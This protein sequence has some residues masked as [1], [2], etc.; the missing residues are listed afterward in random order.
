MA[1]SAPYFTTD[2]EEGETQFRSDVTTANANAEIFE[3]PITS[4]TSSYPIS[5]TGSAGTTVYVKIT[6]NGST[7][8][9][10]NS[11]THSGGHDGN[12][13]LYFDQYSVDTSGDAWSQVVTEGVKFE[14]FSDSG[15]NTPTTLNS[16]ATF[17]WH[18]GTC[19]TN[20]NITPTGTAAGTAVYAVY[21]T[22]GGTTS[23]NRIGN[24]TS[25]I[26]ADVH[27]VALIDDSNSFNHITMVPNGH[28]ELFAMGG[29]LLFSQVPQGSIPEGSGYT[30]SVPPEATFNPANDSSGVSKSSSITISLTEPIRNTDDTT[31]TNDNVDSVITLKDTNSSGS[32]ISFDATINDTK[33]TITITPTSNFTAGQTVYA[34]ISNA[35]EDNDDNALAATTSTFTVASAGTPSASI[36]PANG[37][38]GISLSRNIVITFDEAVRIISGNATLTNDN[39]DALIT[40]K[41]TNAQGADIAFD[42][43]VSSDK[44]TITINPTSNFSKNQIVYAALGDTLEDVDDNA[45]SGI[46]T[47]FTTTSVSL[48]NPLNKSDVKAVIES[49]INLS[50][51]FA[52]SSLNLI[53]RRISWLERNIHNP[54]KSRQQVKFLFGN[55]YLDRLINENYNFDQ[56]KKESNVDNN[57]DNLLESENLENFG[58]LITYTKTDYEL[59]TDSYEK[60]LVS[61]NLDNAVYLSGSEAENKVF[62]DLLKIGTEKALALK[63]INKISTT[64]SYESF[65]DG[66][67]IWSSG[68]IKVGSINLRTD[69]S[70]QKFENNI[71]S[72]GMDKAINENDY[73]GGAIVLGDSDI[74]IGTTSTNMNSNNLGFLSYR[75]FTLSENSNFR[76]IAGL[77]KL[78]I[79][80]V[81]VDGTDNLTG[82]RK[83]NQIYSLLRYNK[84][85]EETEND[86]RYSSFNKL[87]FIHTELDHYNE[88]GGSTGLIFEKEN[89]NKALLSTGL[90]MKHKYGFKNSFI[91][92]PFIQAEYG[93]DISRGSKSHIRY[94]DDT[95]MYSSKNNNLYSTIFTGLIGSDI[96]INDNSSAQITYEFEN[97]TNYSQHHTL[98]F[99]INY[100]F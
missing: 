87:K 44:T 70:Q 39:V 81:R 2:T 38:T 52:N 65:Y 53:D 37:S 59:N 90:E 17:T 33:T 48:E 86:W 35:V 34:A 26:S 36:S 51:N 85:L 13:T 69:T 99:T 97:A 50:S 71:L 78:D 91:I 3:L 4:S 49:Y 7:S 1:V 23:T 61:N 5:V 74:D 22:T 77:G 92:V 42:A 64:P 19:C 58:E 94:I 89:I 25:S 24:I 41:K 80:T 76:F 29:Y 83:A 21:G 40:L 96:H 54:K 8:L 9:L 43:T 30:P 63:K 45:A 14:F 82:K 88:T 93:L 11:V 27:F 100:N 31:L 56:M 60:Y 98:N 12:S 79:K 73:Y 55:Q 72:I 47:K 32:D 62:N 15:M 20:S 84:R 10:D 46:I 68:E 67:S 6:R 66:W 18:W 95:T 16:F 75:S 28:G 57:I